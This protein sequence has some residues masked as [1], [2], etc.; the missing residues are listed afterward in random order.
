LTV[1]SPE[2]DEEEFLLVKRSDLLL[3]HL[4][5]VGPEVGPSRLVV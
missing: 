2:R 1:S 5:K 4:I 3:V